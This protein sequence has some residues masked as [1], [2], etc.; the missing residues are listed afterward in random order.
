MATAARRCEKAKKSMPTVDLKSADLAEKRADPD[1]LLSLYKYL[2]V[3]DV[4]DA[5]DSLGHFDLHLMSEEVRPLWNGMK[6]WG[7]AATIRCVPSNKPMWPLATN[8]EVVDSHSI[9]FEKVGYVALPE[10]L[11]PGHVIVMDTGGSGEVGAW[12][13]ANTLAVVAAGAVGIVTD[14]YCRDTEEVVLQRSP[15]CSRGR[16]RTLIPGRIE[17]IEVQTTI[18]CGGVQVRPGDVVGCDDDGV[19]VV[20]AEIAEQVAVI[21]RAVLIADMVVRR[22]H[23]AEL[24]MEADGTVDVETVQA[25]YSAVESAV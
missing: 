4:C 9:W 17:F 22:K 20:P 11:A 10:T 1:D 21:A 6:F 18:A 7:T 13:S 12:G 3:A 16:G 5:L 19:I 23:Y 15:V 25:Y 14:G 2:R 8:A 24:G